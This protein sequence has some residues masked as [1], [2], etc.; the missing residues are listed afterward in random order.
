MRYFTSYLNSRK[1]NLFFFIFLFNSKSN[2]RGKAEV[3]KTD[4]LKMW[5]LKGSY[6]FILLS[7]KH[8]AILKLS[9]FCNRLLKL[10]FYVT[11]F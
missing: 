9:L 5:Y 2:G 6:I 4:Y 11:Y 3:K 8:E 10:Y 1:N 7:M